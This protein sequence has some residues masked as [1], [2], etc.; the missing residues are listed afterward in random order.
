MGSEGILESLR[1][2]R[3]LKKIGMAL[4]N[5]QRKMLWGIRGARS[6]TRKSKSI[7]I[8][9]GR[10]QAHLEL[11]SIRMVLIFDYILRAHSGRIRAICSLK[12]PNQFDTKEWRQKIEREVFAMILAWL[13]GL[14]V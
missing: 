12:V 14:S 8:D 13:G 6:K 7:E 4:E 5:Q 11:G 2:G 3:H 1:C 10:H 9:H